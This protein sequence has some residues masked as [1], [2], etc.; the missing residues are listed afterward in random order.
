MSIKI[1]PRLRR[2]DVISCSFS[3]CVSDTKK[4]FFWAPEMSVSEIISEPKMFL[5]QTEGTISFEQLQ[6]FADT[7]SWRKFNK[8]MDVINSNV[9]FIDFATLLVNELSLGSKAP[10]FTL[11]SSTCR[12]P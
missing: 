3:N 5:H 4:E 2:T 1:D 7:Y 10:D 11:P 6:G 12:T 9:K 8:Q